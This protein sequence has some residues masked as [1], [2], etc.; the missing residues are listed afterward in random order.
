MAVLSA[1]LRAAVIPDEAMTH[2]T[3]A[4]N[5]LAGHSGVKETL[6]KLDLMNLHWPKRRQHV[7]HFIG[8]CPICQNL[9]HNIFVPEETRAVR[10]VNK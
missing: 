1:V 7:K 5:T 9:D 6:R 3:K 8:Q 2:I 10:D 4:H